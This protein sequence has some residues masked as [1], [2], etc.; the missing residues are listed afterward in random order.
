VKEEN[1][2]S[3]ILLLFVILFLLPLFYV[4]RMRKK[5]INASVPDI[6][7][8]RSILIPNFNYYNSL[9]A[10]SKLE[11]EERLVTFISEKEFFTKPQ[12]SL[13]NKMKVLVS[14]SAIQLTF[15][16]PPV[17]LA[18][19]E[20]IF[21]FP[22]AFYSV[23]NRSFHK[24]EVNMLGSIAISWK[25]FLEGYRI[26][27]DGFNLGLHEMAHALKLGNAIHSNEFGSLDEDLLVFWDKLASLEIELMKNGK[28]FLRQY[29]ASNK[30][31]FFAV[32]VEAFFEIPA[33][34]IASRP[35]L[36]N[37]LAAL[38]NQNPLNQ[39]KENQFTK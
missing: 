6:G 25:H 36:Y 19:F 31:E 1:P 14:A 9:S 26:S 12:S 39:N 24:G 11:F 5:K 15:G 16:L 13:N 2:D 33:K 28:A 29:G 35:E 32:A 22:A 17:Y 8:I 18:H 3:W 38:L 34:F 23:S 7:I 27:N 10:A 4:M 20:K 30:E 37:T 21:I